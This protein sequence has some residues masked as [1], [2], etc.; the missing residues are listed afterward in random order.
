MSAFS[1]MIKLL[2]C[3]GVLAAA[4]F[5]LSSQP[6][7]DH[8]ATIRDWVKLWHGYDDSLAERCVAA[9]LVRFHPRDEVVRSR[10][11]LKH[12]VEHIRTA[13][14]DF[15]VEVRKIEVDERG[16]RL[17]WTVTG[18]HTGPGEGPPTGKKVRLD[19]SDAFVIVDGRITQN[20]GYW[21][22]NEFLAQLEVPPM[23][24]LA[25]RNLATML[26]WPNE[27]ANQGRYDVLAEIFTEDHEFDENGMRYR[28]VDG[29]RRHIETVREAFDGFHLEI[30]AAHCDGYRGSAR[31]IATGTHTG[32]FF[33]IPGTG[34]QVRVQGQTFSEFEGGKVHRSYCSWDTASLLRQL[35]GT[36]G[37][38]TPANA[39]TSGK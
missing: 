31:W 37:P 35:G 8:E 23:V 26:R 13:F 14:P 6:V 4:P 16:G 10:G 34:R 28:G 20:W 2:C 1:Y 36:G 25:H 33:G 32:E 11:D 19:G 24:P 7:Q 5:V 22:Q 27:A 3:A 38:A 18:T 30:V 17:L 15:A 21:D 12:L 29:M 9:D 39:S